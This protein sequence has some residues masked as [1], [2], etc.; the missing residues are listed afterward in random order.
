MIKTL[1]DNTQES[2]YDFFILPASGNDRAPLDRVRRKDCDLRRIDDRRRRQGV[3]TAIIGDRI[4]PTFEFRWRQL[5]FPGFFNEPVNGAGNA[6]HVHLVGVV[7][8]RNDKT[9]TKLA[10]EWSR[11]SDQ[12]QF[13]VIGAAARLPRPNDKLV[14]IARD[15]VHHDNVR[16]R[17]AAVR[18]L[19]ASR[20]EKHVEL[21]GS[22]LRGS[23]SSGERSAAREALRRIGTEKAAEE[24]LRNLSAFPQSQQE[25]VRI[26]FER[27]RDK[28]A[29]LR[30]A[31]E[32][33]R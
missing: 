14:D 24:V 27:I 10:D 2:R 6:G 3:E 26:Q 31:A 11:L 19:G 1:T 4:G 18:V 15:T 7:N 9:V 8:D 22:V 33:R 17:T 16:V 25:S 12:A 30:Q 23:R 28:R 13:A 21:L 32:S 29:R 5:A 20:N